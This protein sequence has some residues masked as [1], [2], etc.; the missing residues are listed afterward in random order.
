MS[1]I[2]ILISFDV[3]PARL[4]VVLSQNVTFAMKIFSDGLTNHASFHLLSFDI[5]FSAR[6]EPGQVLLDVKSPLMYHHSCF[7]YFFISDL[8]LPAP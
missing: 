1:F 6:I 2:T 7:F 8:H 3:E 4:L 5:H